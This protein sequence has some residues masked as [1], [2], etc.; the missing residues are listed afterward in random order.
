MCVYRDELAH[1]VGVHHPYIAH[2]LMAHLLEVIEVV[3]HYVQC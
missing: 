2:N 1:S 3:V